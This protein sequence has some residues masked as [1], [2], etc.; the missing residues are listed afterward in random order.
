MKELKKDNLQKQMLITT[1]RTW[2][3]RMEDETFNF[4][5]ASCRL[6]TNSNAAASSGPKRLIAWPNKSPTFRRP[7]QAQGVGPLK[8]TTSTRTLLPPAPCQRW[9][10]A[11]L[12]P[13]TP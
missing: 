12:P 4:D 2:S 8:K 11:L 10:L 13:V 6:H 7:V 3:V 5:S 1:V 9:P